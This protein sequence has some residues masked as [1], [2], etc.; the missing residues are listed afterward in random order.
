A[1]LAGLDEDARRA[2]LLAHDAGVPSTDQQP[3]APGALLRGLR[4][5]A[6]DPEDDP[7]PRVRC[8]RAPAALADWVLDVAAPAPASDVRAHVDGCPA[9]AH[10]ARLLRGGRRRLEGLPP[11]PDLGP[12][13]IAS[14]LAGTAGGPAPAAPAAQTGAGPARSVLDDLPPPPFAPA[15]AGADPTREVRLP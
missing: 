8:A 14:A 1:S 6:G 12:R 3:G 13:L 5:L 4:R 7:A 15:E 2:V 9:C 11:V 10:A